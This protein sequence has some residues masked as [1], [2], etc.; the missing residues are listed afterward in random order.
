MFSKGIHLPNGRRDHGFPTTNDVIPAFAAPAAA[1]V[2]GVATKSWSADAS[3][4]YETSNGSTTWKPL[5]S[6]GGDSSPNRTHL[7][8]ETDHSGLAGSGEAIFIYLI[9]ALLHLNGY[10]LAVFIYRCADNEQLQSLVERVRTSHRLRLRPAI[11]SSFVGR[12]LGALQMKA[13][14]QII[15]LPFVLRVEVGRMSYHTSRHP[16]F[17]VRSSVMD[18]CIVG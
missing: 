1:T 4:A 14:E 16:V 18:G 11:T 12:A 7:I 17:R 8:I 15:R 5:A 10:L 13:F 3:R 2:S 9:P 6:T